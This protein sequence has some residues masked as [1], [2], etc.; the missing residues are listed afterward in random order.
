[1]DADILL[2][3]RGRHLTTRG[4]RPV[5]LRG[6]GLGGWMNMENFITGFP[7]TETLQRAALERALGE[8]GTRRFFDRF[9]DV[10]FGDAD[11]AFIASLGLNVVRLPVNYRHFD[12]D[13][14]PEKQVVGAE[15]LTGLVGT[16][17]SVP[18]INIYRFVLALQTGRRQSESRRPSTTGFPARRRGRPVPSSCPRSN[19]VPPAFRLSAR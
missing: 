2:Q 14:R 5:V 17:S 3:V 7:G 6:V 9:L 8:Q 16:A 19:S 11:A 18:V 1:M 15:I 12:D 4:G 13:L 10:F